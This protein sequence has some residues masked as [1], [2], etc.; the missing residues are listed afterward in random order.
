MDRKILWIDTETTGTNPER[1][2]IIQ[3]AALMEVSGEV[4]D[5]YEAKMAPHI[6]AAIDHAALAISGTT[7]NELA[8][9]SPSHRVFFEFE[10]W[11]CG[12]INPYDKT[13]KAFPAGYNVR[14]DLEFVEKWFRHSGHKY[15]SGSFQ[16][17]RWLDPLAILH[18]EAFLGEVDFPDFKL[19]TVCKLAGIELDAHDALSDIRAT[20]ELTRMLAPDIFCRPLL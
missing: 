19:G 12:H 11:L 4:V 1:H 8:E 6:D 3:I 14:F 15:G 10:N 20:R 13:D 18:R 9:R 17:W 7:I 2:G 16:N 5:E